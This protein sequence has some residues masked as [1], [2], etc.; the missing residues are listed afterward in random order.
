MVG[1]GI[2]LLKRPEEF[3]S[4]KPGIAQHLLAQHFGRDRRRFVR[5]QTRGGRRRCRHRELHNLIL[6]Q[7]VRRRNTGAQRADIERL[8]KLNKLDPDRSAASQEH[9]HLQPDPRGAALLA[10]LQLRAFLACLGFHWDVP[11]VL[12]N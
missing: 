11:V 9:G 3:Q 6:A 5:Y 12:A 7:D 2:N 4:K 1:S 8:S 10:I